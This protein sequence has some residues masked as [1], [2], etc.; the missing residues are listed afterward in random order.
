LAAGLVA[1]PFGQARAHIPGGRLS[2]GFGVAT[3]H[4]HLAAGPLS[5]V[6][7]PMPIGSFPDIFPIA[8]PRLTIPLTQPMP[9]KSLK[10]QPPLPCRAGWFTHA[11][12]DGAQICADGQMSGT[13]R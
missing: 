5:A 4:R 3:G 1:H 11:W 6:S 9:V 2:H 8:E 12:R 13:S 10:R 7:P